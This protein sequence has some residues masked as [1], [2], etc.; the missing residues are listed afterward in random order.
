VR[1]WDGPE[2]DGAFSGQEVLVRTKAGAE[3]H[4]TLG[5]QAESNGRAKTYYVEEQS[6]LDVTAQDT[7]HANAE[8]EVTVTDPG[9]YE[10]ADGVIFVVKPNRAKTAL[11]AKRLVE[12][13]AD[14]ALEEGGR[15]QIEFEYEAGA[16]FTL[17]PED[18]MPLER[19]KELTLR[20]GRCIVCGR[21]LKAAESVE[22]GIGPVCIK[23]FAG[24][25]TPGQLDLESV[26]LQEVS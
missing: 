16:V 14:R 13:N 17:A 19:A 5:Q 23:S 9:V 24:W 2:L 25:T 12:I 10:R 6:T 1:V 22:R 21:K 4:V 3:R 20:Y 11:Y 26:S 8:R 18:K 7:E 15:V